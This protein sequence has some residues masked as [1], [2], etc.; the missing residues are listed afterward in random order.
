MA[1][2]NFGVITS[3]AGT[4]SASAF[5]DALVAALPPIYDKESPNT[6]LRRIYTALAQELAKVDITLGSVANNNYLSV[7]ITDELQIRGAGS[8]DR[9]KNEN[10]FELDQIR[11]NPPGSRVFQN[12]ILKQGTNQ[13]QL[14]FIPED[15]DFIIFD[16][17][18]STQTPLNFPT[19]FVSSTNILTILSPRQGPFTVAY[20]DTGNVVRLNQNIT[21]PA[22]L[23]LLGWDEGGYG[24]LGYDE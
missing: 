20:R 8:L 2:S 6:V 9:L 22:E 10:A 3:A 16:A 1:D 24:D 7:A 4:H 12:V 13:L 21:V 18:D 14:Y 23:F 17:T 11:L 19:T 5:T 15:I